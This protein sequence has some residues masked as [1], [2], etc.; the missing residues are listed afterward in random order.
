MP[1]HGPDTR[2]IAITGVDALAAEALRDPGLDLRA[3]GRRLAELVDRVI[4][5]ERHPS[6]HRTATGGDSRGAGPPR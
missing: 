6:Q 5:P 4:A 3:T 1:G 2:A